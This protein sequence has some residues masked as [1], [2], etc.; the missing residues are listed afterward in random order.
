MLQPRVPLRRA[1]SAWQL[2]SPC[3]RRAYAQVVDHP[4]VAESYNSAVP[5][6]QSIPRD[7]LEPIR[8]ERTLRRYTPRTP[9]IRHLIRPIND[10]LWRGRPHHP[11]TMPKKGHAKGGRNHTGRVVLR[12]RGGGAKRRI[13][14]VDF[15]RS[16][17]GAHFVERIEHDPGRTAH[18][19][20]VRSQVSGDWT[21]IVAAEHMRAGDFI[22]SYRAGLPE[23]MLS[24]MGGQVDRGLVASK[25]A[26]RGNCLPLGMIPIGMPI[27]N[28]TPDK[29]SKA[30]MCRSAGTY[31]TVIGKGEDEVQKEMLKFIGDQGAAGI[32]GGGLAL[33]SLTSA[34]LR[35]YEKASNF[36][37]VRLSSGEIR[38]IDKEA[39]ATIGVASNAN[40]SYTSLGK[41]GRKRW[42]GIRPTVRGLAMNAV[43]HPHGGGRGKGKGNNDPVSPWGMPVSSFAE[44]DSFSF[45]DHQRTAHLLTFYRPN[46]VTRLDRSTKSTISSSKSDHE[47]KANGGRT[48]NIDTA[49]TKS[50]V[51]PF[52]TLATLVA[53]LS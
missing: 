24:S 46:Q 37:T 5:E 48:H 36:V 52:Y 25:T 6:V 3:F 12:H 45:S 22:Q 18:I 34:Q 43:D 39:V 53:T 30:T 11:L 41:A 23:E 33:S 8:G 42:L 14:T 27:F 2:L 51:Q 1:C 49:L 17:P 44:D 35:R 40:Y 4:L 10:H 31:A 47:I 29:S 9:G 28:I 26:L 21:Y 19:A 20:L 50:Q 7:K 13:R 38:L 15:M 16:Q 32:E